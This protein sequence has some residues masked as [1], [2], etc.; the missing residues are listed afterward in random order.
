LGATY[1]A[2]E[3]CEFVRAG[4]HTS[5]TYSWDRSMRLAGKI[6]VVTGAALGLG[7]AI[8]ERYA[9]EGATVIAAD[10]NEIEGEK[11]IERL[12]K[13]GCDA[14]FIATDVSDEHAVRQ[15]FQKVK[16]RH[17]RIDV[18]C[19][20]AAVLLYD[21]DAPVHDLSVDTWDCVMNVNLRGAFLCTRYALPLMLENGGGSIIYMGSP[22]GLYGC[23]PKLT[24]YSTSKAGVMGLARVTAIAYAHQNIRVN[25][26]VPGT[27]D[28]PMNVPVL[29]DPVSRD[30]FSKA[31]PLGRL[32]TAQDI[33][34]IALF[35]AS[36]ESAYCTGGLYMCDGG[37]TAV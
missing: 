19:I 10:V 29:T 28:T 13:D 25:S 20:S 35:L 30:E 5:G 14:S 1:Y 17:G 2:L 37:L 7:R 8:A 18:L 31:V 9:H 26:I 16:T 21:R 23:A 4:G 6:T 12:Q 11:F 34:G 33:E 36:D 27:M 24:A 22:T 3:I 32:G 15:L